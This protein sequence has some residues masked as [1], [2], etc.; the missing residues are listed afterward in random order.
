MDESFSENLVHRNHQYVEIDP[1]KLPIIRFVFCLL[2]SLSRI[3]LG[4]SWKVLW[5]Q[6]SW[7]SMVFFCLANLIFAT[8][9]SSMGPCTNYVV[10]NR[11]FFMVSQSMSSNVVFLK[12]VYK[13]YVV[14]SKM[15][16][17]RDFKNWLSEN[18]IISKTR[19][20]FI[21]GLLLRLA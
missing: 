8:F 17:P 20:I 15:V 1:E 11:D 3:V 10:Q 12:M 2:P 4:W 6:D 9:A 5:F 18:T 7:F 21:F 16:P 14:F 13:N 19:E